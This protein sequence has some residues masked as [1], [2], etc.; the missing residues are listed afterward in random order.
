[1]RTHSPN[2]DRAGITLRLKIALDL[3]GAD[4]ALRQSRRELLDL[5]I[6]ADARAGAEVEVAR[7]RNLD[8]AA[9][10]RR[11]ADNEGAVVHSYIAIDRAGEI[12]A[13]AVHSYTSLDLTIV[14]KCAV[15]PGGHGH[16]AAERTVETAVAALSRGEGESCGFLAKPQ[17]IHLPTTP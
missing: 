1:M 4:R 13:P 5:Q 8:I 17:E 7:L 3:D 9:D 15:L 12:E 14:R 6:A 11:W 2:F 10:F 16:V